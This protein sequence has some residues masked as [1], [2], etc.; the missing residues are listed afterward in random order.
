MGVSA[1]GL[2]HKHGF[3]YRV[4]DDNSWV[5]KESMRHATRAAYNWLSIIVIV[6]NNAWNVFGRLSVTIRAMLAVSN[7]VPHPSQ[8]CGRNACE[9]PMGF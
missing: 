8:F 2:A 9:C 7:H 4:N 5:P 3:A 6:F 1:Q